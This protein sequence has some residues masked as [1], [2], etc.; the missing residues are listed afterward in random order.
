[1]RTYR[2][3]KTG[4]LYVAFGHAETFDKAIDCTNSR[5]GVKVVIYHAEDNNW[6]LFV[7]EREEFLE[8]FTFVRDESPTQEYR[9]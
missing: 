2:H 4:N 7:R 9:T 1:M 3:N 5:D 6:Q 8:K